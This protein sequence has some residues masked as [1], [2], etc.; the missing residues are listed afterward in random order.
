LS[1][2]LT[3]DRQRPSAFLYLLDG[4]TIPDA[5]LAVFERRLGVSEAG[6]YARFIRPERRRQFLLGRMLLRSAVSNLVDAP[7]AAI[8]IVER[9]GLGPALLLSGAHFPRPCFSLSHSRHWIACAVSVDTALGLDLEVI[10]PERDIVGLSES[11][12]D[13]CESAWFIR[14][15]EHAR[16]A[17]FYRLWSLKEALFKLRSNLGKEQQTRS[18]VNAD[19]EL[20]SLGDGWFSCALPHRDLSIAICS[21]QPLQAVSMIEQAELADAG[22]PAI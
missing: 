20:A 17:G 11:A 21:A 3:I 2:S 10:D 5:E 18:L 13:A 8:S 12:F 16:V 14:Q 6:R 1:R 7:P 19:G 22:W 4:R 15:P 9:D